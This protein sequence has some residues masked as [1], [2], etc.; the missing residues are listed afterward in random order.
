M[1]FTDLTS[2]I[3][4]ARY[5]HGE[6]GKPFTVVQQHTGGMKILAEQWVMRKQMRVM[7]ST[8]HDRFHTVLPGI[9]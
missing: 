7:Y 2:A 8:R 4:E 6:T 9:K 3:E 1:I 5:R